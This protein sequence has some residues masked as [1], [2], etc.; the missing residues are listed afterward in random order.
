MESSRR[1]PVWANIFFRWAICAGLAVIAVYTTET[2]IRR[3]LWDLQVYQRAL[4]LHRS[5]GTPFQVGPGM[6]FIYPPV[7]LTLFSWLGAAFRPLL[8]TLYAAVL[9][10]MARKSLRPVVM[11]MALF[12]LTI[13]FHTRPVAIALGSGNLTFFFHALLIL[14][15]LEG[16]RWQ[17]RLFPGL[18]ILFSLLKPYYL[19]YALMPVLVQGLG[20]GGL[21][22][23]AMI[24]A[25]TGVGWTVQYLAAPEAFRQFLVAL[26]WQSFQG[27]DALVAGDIG[28]GGYRFM[29]M[30]TGSA[31]A[32]LTLHAGLAAVFLGAV[33]RW[34]GRLAALGDRHGVNVLGFVALISVILINPRLKIYDYCFIGSLAAYL[35]AF[36][37]RDCRKGW[38]I[39]V[40]LILHFGEKQ[41]GP[42]PVDRFLDAHLLTVVLVVLLARA[43]RELPVESG[44]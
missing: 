18:V 27:N 43:L 22:R 32:A 13:F 20:P 9:L 11:G 39:L 41:I 33:L 42:I 12:S 21:A 5:G 44:P 16:G 30:A 10:L 34:R 2:V 17:T 23:L 37:L 7:F 24:V 35:V 28:W 25:V 31:Q 26:K 36:F 19:A 14:S 8:L 3:D 40:W 38:L 6:N 29:A 1:D 15:W 4:D